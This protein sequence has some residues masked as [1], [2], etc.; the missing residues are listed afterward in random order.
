MGQE[1][2]P[3]FNNIGWLEPQ[4]CTVDSCNQH[5]G[6]GGGQTHLHGDPFGEFCMYSL[7][8]YTSM[9]DHPPQLGWIFD[10]LATF[11]RHVSTENLGY[12]VPLDDC[13][14]HTHD[15]MEYHYH[16]QI[17]QVTT[18]G[19]V[20]STP[21]TTTDNKGISYVA[22]TTGPW[23]CLKGDISVIPNYWNYWKGPESIAS[24]VSVVP[25]TTNDMC[26]GTTEYYVLGG[27]RWDL[28]IIFLH[29]VNHRIF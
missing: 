1:I 20:Y 23:Q 2:F 22:T 4:K 15:G 9:S 21:Q 7:K 12:N 8:N 14:G 11:G 27:E 10:G 3:V 29:S 6:A 24:H 13:G 28:L 19:G 17:L 26:F 18:D 5:I 25:D 16:A